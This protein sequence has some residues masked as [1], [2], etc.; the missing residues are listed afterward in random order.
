MALGHG[1]VGVAGEHDLTLFGDLQPAGDRSGR[2][3]DDG[4]VQR[5][6]ATA[7]GAATAVEQ[8]ELRSWRAAQ[9]T[10]SPWV[11]ARFRVALAG[12]TSLAESE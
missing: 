8:G 9:V 12:P 6:T 1:G 2:L 5:T 11:R 7:Q 10:R 4:P 3:G